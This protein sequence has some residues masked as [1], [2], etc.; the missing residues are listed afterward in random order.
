MIYKKIKIA[1]SLIMVIIIL[2]GATGCWNRREIQDLAVATAVGFDR[3]MINGSPRVIL[4]VLL[5]R[6]SPAGG[7][8][9]RGGGGGGP[10]ASPTGTVITI[11]GE[12]INDAIRN[13][14][15]RSSRI[16]FFGHTLVIV[17]GEDMARQGIDQ[18][19]EFLNRQLDVRPRTW[20]VVSKGTARDAL[21]ALPEFEPVTS[22]EIARILELDHD[23]VSKSAAVNLFQ[24]MYDML[25]PGREAAVSWLKLFV[26]REKMS[27]ARMGGAGSTGASQGQPKSFYI[28]GSAVFRGDRMVGRL[29]KAESQGLL[30]VTSKAVGGSIP[31]SLKPPQ[32]DTSFVLRTSKAKVKPVIKG[33]RVTFE[34]DIRGIGDLN[35]QR[36]GEIGT[37]EQDFK[38]VE[39]L[40]N[41]EV[42]KRVLKAVAKAKELRSD[43][44]G[45]G[46]LIHR[47]RPGEW[48]RIKSNW[49]KIFPTVQVRV[50]VKMTLE[51]IGPTGEPIKIQ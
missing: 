16:I 8:G 13:W 33:N 38:K 47:S 46:D 6:P 42:E 49:E 35:E 5:T 41:K 45:F 50:K 32:K 22:Q 43:V 26:P 29:D 4:T 12:T 10:T 21:Q 44:F 40:V 17:I 30:F 7:G 25:T 15:L 2:A 14:F 28:D 31:V 51:N 36:A 20:V 48:K 37:L 1:I 18:V 11:E 27:P 34:I 3:S 19:V 39:R 24:V 23:W 9:S